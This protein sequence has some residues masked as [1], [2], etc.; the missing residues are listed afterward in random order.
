MDF[1]KMYKKHTK[2]EIEE[3][4][5]EIKIFFDKNDIKLESGFDVVKACKKIGFTMLSLSLP[6]GIDGVIMV[7]KK[8]K[9]IGVSNKTQP[10]DAR[11]VI[12]HEL[13]H[14]IHELRDKKE[15]EVLFA[16]K[17]SILHG[18]A[19]S[20]LENLIDLI[21]ASILVPKDEFLSDMKKYGIKKTTEI[22]EAKKTSFNAIIE[23]SAKY[24][25]AEDLIIRRVVEVSC[26]A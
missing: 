24:D 26:Y 25:V 9:V 21:A 4:E 7:G 14:Y 20:D 15:D 12:A 11:F 1:L 10:Q 3:V 6:Q 17:D 18:V 19:K 16:M 22:D 13:G 2:E 23:L 5:K 8:G